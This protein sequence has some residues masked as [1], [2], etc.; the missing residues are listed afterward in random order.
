MFSDRASYTY[1]K[2]P[3]AVEKILESKGNLKQ[4]T[5]YSDEYQTY[6]DNYLHQ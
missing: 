3:Y 1:N 6:S 2:A 4:D 5:T